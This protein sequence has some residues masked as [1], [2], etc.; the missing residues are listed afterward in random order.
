MI[1]RTQMTVRCLGCAET[2]PIQVTIID[3]VAGPAVCDAC[4]SRRRLA[5]RLPE[6]RQHRS[7]FACMSSARR[8]RGRRLVDATLSSRSSLIAEMAAKPLGKRVCGSCPRQESNLC[9][10]FRKSLGPG[11]C[12]TPA[13]ALSVRSGLE[14]ACCTSQSAGFRSVRPVLVDGV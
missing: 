11:T 4:I 14:G 2:K 8:G 6:P 5:R 3:D 12:S 9:T 13:S 7:L 1:V 10:R